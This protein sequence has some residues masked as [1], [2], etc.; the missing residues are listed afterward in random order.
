M[1]QS[2]FDLNLLRL[3]VVKLS[4]AWIQTVTTKIV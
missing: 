1:N 3:L 2:S 4:K